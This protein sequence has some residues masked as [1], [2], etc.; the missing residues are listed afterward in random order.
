MKVDIYVTINLFWN[1]KHASPSPE[2]ATDPHGLVTDM[3]KPA[4]SPPTRKK[5][6]MSF[7][8]QGLRWVTHVKAGAASWSSSNRAFDISRT[9]V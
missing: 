5:V 9:C 6:A 1:V 8:T 3:N 4:E 2:I 7:G